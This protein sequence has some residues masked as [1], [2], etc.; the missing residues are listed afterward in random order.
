MSRRTSTISPS[1]MSSRN[2]EMA[3]RPPKL[4]SQAKEDARAMHI[5]GG[6]YEAEAEELARA[7][8]TVRRIAPQHA[9]ELLDAL[10][11]DVAS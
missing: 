3:A 5:L 10:G 9:D 4:T 7:A 8:R 6:I 11:L 1:E 2:I